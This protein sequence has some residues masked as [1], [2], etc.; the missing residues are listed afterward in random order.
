MLIFFLSRLQT[1]RCYGFL[2]LVIA[3]IIHLPE[4]Y[5]TS[6]RRATNLDT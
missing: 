6:L 1:F 4:Q 2:L 5:F 3:F